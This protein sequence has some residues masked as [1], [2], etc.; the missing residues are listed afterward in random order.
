MIEQNMHRDKISV[1]SL[2]SGCGGMDLGFSKS[3]Y[4]ILEAYD[5]WGPA[6]DN[7]YKNKN[8]LGGKPIRASLALADGEVS[9]ETFPKV[10]VVLGGPPCQGY[11]FAGKQRI[12]DPRNFLYQD[13][14]RIVNHLKPQ[15]FLMENVRGLEAMALDDIKIS[16]QAI[17]YNVWV[18]KVKAIDLG[19]PQRRERIIIIGTKVGE[20]EFLTPSV[21]MGPLFGAVEPQ[22]V[23]DA[24]GD[25]PEPKAAESQKI[26]SNHYLDDHVFLPLSEEAQNFIKHIP[27]GGYFM[28]APRETLPKRLQM[29]FDNPLKYKSPRLFPKAAPQ[30]PSQTVPA[31]SSPSIGGVIAPDFDYANGRALAI[32]PADHTI[33][34]IYVSPKTSR[35]FT[36]REAA[37]LQTFP[38]EYLFTGSITT[39]IKLI[40][41]AV[42]V[43]MAQFLAEEIKK[44]IFD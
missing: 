38:D 43:K 36:P 39:K 28:N 2:F 26:S 13:F 20:K 25:L 14:L 42:P 1:L 8:L 27:N 17:N 11:S 32:N 6:I 35:R 19:I 37:R 10:E 34:G 31:S 40:G 12:D 22:N 3:G 7:Q 18:H 9:L 41:N 4:R 5:N 24:I 15:V 33:K 44:Q 23:I 16:F 21:L 29:I 30:N